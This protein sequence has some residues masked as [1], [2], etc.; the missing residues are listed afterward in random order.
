MEF[1]KIKQVK[2][3]KKSAIIAD[4]ILKMIKS[5]QYDAGSKLPPERTLAEQMGVGRPSVR[6]AISALQIVGILESRPGDGS[7]VAEP[8][9]FDDLM[10]R[11]LNMLEDSDSPLE[12]LEA[13]KALEIGIVYLA[14]K[15]ATEEDIRVIKDA[16][17]KKYE[18]GRTGQYKDFIRLGQEFHL[19]IA[20]ATK[21]AAIVSVLNELIKINMQPLWVNMR[22]AYLK[23]DRAHIDQM[24]ALHADI[25]K[26]IE[27][28]NSQRAIHLMEAHFDINIK[29]QYRDNEVKHNFDK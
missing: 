27:E 11:A 20:R 23:Q 9:G 1:E 18:K 24:I 22:S 26:A 4:Q 21:S 15:N 10:A 6:E 28:R 8:S 3:Q 13:R 19:A 16:W 14:I 12:V 5:G 25:V 17:E 29:Q 2:F 7:Y